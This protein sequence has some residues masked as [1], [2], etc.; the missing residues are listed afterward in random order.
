MIRD[1]QGLERVILAAPAPTTS[2]LLTNDIKSY[3]HAPPPLSRTELDKEV[4]PRLVI[5]SAQ[6]SW[7]LIVD[8]ERH[9]LQKFLS[10]SLSVWLA[11]KDAPVC[12]MLPSNA[13]HTCN[14]SEWTCACMASATLTGTKP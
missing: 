3:G 9:K 8:W 10:L 1:F 6:M 2:W 14:R 12:K 4:A 11:A 5:Y 13:A 7:E